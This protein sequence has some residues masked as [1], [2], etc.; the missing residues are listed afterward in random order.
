MRTIGFIGAGNMGG[1][2]I[3]GLVNAGGMAAQ[4]IYVHDIH[5]SE[6]IKKLGVQV[7][8]LAQVVGQAD[9][10][11]LAVKPQVMGS[12]LDEV[13]ASG[14]VD[15]KTVISIAAGIT[16]EFLRKHLG[17]GV[18][19]VRVMPNLAL[20]V[21]EGMTVI[22][23]GAGVTEQEA[24]FARSIFDCV[25]K[26]LVVSEDAIDKCIAINGSS[27]AFVFMFI[28]A[29]ADAGVKNGIPRQDAYL[30]AEQT[31]LGSAK[32]ALESGVHP[33][34][35]KDMVCSPGGTTIDA[36]IALEKAG[37]RAAVEDAA[38]VCTQKA[39]A[40]RDVAKKNEE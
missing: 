3:A 4:D 16:L 34:A 12:V 33:G 18:H 2:I 9:C 30:L 20:K 13:R 15:G 1:A 10:L 27:P 24:D 7:C 29:L 17:D 8:S 35:L 6:E 14:L 19:L 32:L 40:M 38:Q 5:I 31:V 11:V 39:F 25:G 22:S 21:G 28:E 36:V 23:Y 37:F 26:T